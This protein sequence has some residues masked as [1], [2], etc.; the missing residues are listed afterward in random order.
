MIGQVEAN[1]WVRH[2][3]LEYGQ[4]SFKDSK[5]QSSVPSAVLYIQD[6]VELR[7]HAHKLDDVVA[8]LLHSDMKERP[9]QRV[10]QPAAARAP[11]EQD[12][13]GDKVARRGSDVNREQPI[14]VT[15]ERRRRIGMHQLVEGKVQVTV[16]SG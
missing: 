1:M 15:L 9:S 6:R 2:Q 12:D 4:M 10:A 3:S 13:D 7:S 16:E 5:M 14:V 8:P 11:Y